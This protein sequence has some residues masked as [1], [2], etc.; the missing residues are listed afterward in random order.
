RD[1]LDPQRIL[2]LEVRGFASCAQRIEAALFRAGGCGGE[3]RQLED[4]PGATVEL[5]QADGQL[6]PFGRHLDLGTGDDGG[7]RGCGELDAIAAQNDRR[8]LGSSSSTAKAA[9]TT[10]ETT[11]A[12][13]TGGCAGA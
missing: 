11:A 12:T 13:R 7:L 4:H 10:A 5:T 6:L 8:L 3:S 1:D 2:A 9:E